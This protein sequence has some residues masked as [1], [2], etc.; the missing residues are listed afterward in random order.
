MTK[1]DW[2][3]VEERLKKQFAIVVLDCDGYRLSLTLKQ[4][5][6]MGLAIFTYINGE[7]KGRWMLEDCEECR[8][9]LYPRVRYVMSAKDRK[10]WVKDLG[11]RWLKAHN[12][13][14]DKTYTAYLPWWKS[15]RS[16]KAHLIKNNTSIELVSEAL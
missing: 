6:D 3:Y 4:I 16:L 9:F 12:I 14:V 11:K 13:D 1:Q 10:S 7:F 5:S 8:R 15:F 2:A